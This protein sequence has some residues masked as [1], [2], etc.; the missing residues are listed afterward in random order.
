MSSYL[1]KAKE[2]RF[3]TDTPLKLAS[4]KAQHTNHSNE[5]RMQEAIPTL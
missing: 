5:F 2:L 3:H 4:V 1:W